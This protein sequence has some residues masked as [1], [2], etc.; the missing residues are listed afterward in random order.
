MK[1]DYWTLGSEPTPV[2]D[3]I[4]SVFNVD[5]DDPA[6]FNKKDI[7]AFFEFLEDIGTIEPG[8]KDKWTPRQKVSVLREIMSDKEYGSYIKERWAN[9][10]HKKNWLKSYS[11]E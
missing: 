8:I 1:P 4:A 11:G 6:R 2:S 7:D 10:N 9:S 5:F 3:F